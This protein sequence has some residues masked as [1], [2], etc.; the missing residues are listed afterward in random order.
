[1]VPKLEKL[2]GTLIF[3]S[4]TRSTKRRGL[5]AARHIHTLH[6]GN[7]DSYLRTALTHAESALQEGRCHAAHKAIMDA[8]EAQGAIRAHTREGGGKAPWHPS[9]RIGEVNGLFNDRCL[10]V[11]PTD[12]GAESL[13][14]ARRGAAPKP[15]WQTVLYERLPNGKPGRYTFDILGPF[16]TKAEAN[17]AKRNASREEQRQ[18]PRFVPVVERERKRT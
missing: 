4:K 16:R 3:M 10:R 6:A 7:A 5:G 14:G 17:T 18:P 13:S 15:G 11:S 9:G 1:L 2:R 8:A 12:R